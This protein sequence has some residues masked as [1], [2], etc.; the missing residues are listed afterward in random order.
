MG[1]EGYELRKALAVLGMHGNRMVRAGRAGDAAAAARHRADLDAQVPA[2]LAAAGERDR[3]RRRPRLAGGLEGF[4]ENVRRYA[5][6]ATEEGRRP[7][8]ELLAEIYG[9]ADAAGRE[10]DA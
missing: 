2:V 8:F 4:L 3:L 1:P 9:P 7:F 10:G 6:A 5:A